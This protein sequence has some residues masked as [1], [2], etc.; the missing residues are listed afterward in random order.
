MRSVPIFL[1]Y[2]ERS[3]ASTGR[4]LN[5]TRAQVYA[6]F[7]FAALKC[8]GRLVARIGWVRAVY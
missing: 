5:V 8:A 3:R 7:Y 4:Q 1:E 6:F 2:P